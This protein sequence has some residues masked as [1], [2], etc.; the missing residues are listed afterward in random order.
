MAGFPPNLAYDLFEGLIPVELAECFG[1]LIAM[2]YFTFDNLNE[3]IQALPYKWGDK[4]NCSHLL[5]CAFQSKRKKKKNIGGNA[6]ENWCLLRLT[7]LIV[8]ELIPED[9]P[10]WKIILDLKDIVDLVVCPVH[11]NES[12]TYLENKMSEHSC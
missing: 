12:I 7:A 8:G 9:E 10:D 11:T 6:H 3:L 4:T 5:P 2:K 1:L